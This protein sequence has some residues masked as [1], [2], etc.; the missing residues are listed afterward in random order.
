MLSYDTKAA[1][2]AHLSDGLIDLL[3]AKKLSTTKAAQ[4][5]FLLHGSVEF[6]DSFCL[7]LK[8]ESML[9]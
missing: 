7:D 2:Y 1:P 6:V 5:D 9:S 8:K 3:Y 4:V